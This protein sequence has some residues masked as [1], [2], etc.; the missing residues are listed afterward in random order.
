MTCSSSMRRISRGTPGVKKKRALPMVTAKP[1]AVP[2]PPQQSGKKATPTPTP[3]P[4][5]ATPTATPK[6][7]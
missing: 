2:N 7:K 4:K 3:T 5:K 1:Q 6:K